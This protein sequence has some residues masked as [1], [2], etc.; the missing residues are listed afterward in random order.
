MK[1]SRLP[2]QSNTRL[3]NMMM[4]MMTILTLTHCFNP[5]CVHKTGSASRN[6]EQKKKTTKRKCI[7]PPHRAP[8]G[9]FIPQVHHTHV[10][11]LYI[12]RDDAVFMRARVHI[13][14]S[15]GGM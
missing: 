12:V 2:H 15:R 13:E 10:A 9:T 8:P 3:S 11:V 6:E 7:A 5:A 14:V 1:P 4:M